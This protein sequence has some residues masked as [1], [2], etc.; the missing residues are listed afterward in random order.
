MSLTNIFHFHLPH[1]LVVGL[2]DSHDCVGVLV[3][4][5]G[6]DSVGLKPVCNPLQA[7]M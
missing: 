6:L 7:K 5:Q 3:S 4:V 2:T 1:C